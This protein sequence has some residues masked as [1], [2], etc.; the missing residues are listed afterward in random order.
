MEKFWKLPKSAPVALFAGF[1]LGVKV[2]V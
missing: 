2:M 1:G